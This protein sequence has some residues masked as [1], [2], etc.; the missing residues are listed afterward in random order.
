MDAMSIPDG[1]TLDI[2]WQAPLQAD[3]RDQLVSALQAY[4][5]RLIA[6]ETNP[7]VPILLALG[8]LSNDDLATITR[9]SR[10]GQRRVIAALTTPAIGEPQLAWQLL[11]RGASEVLSWSDLLDDPSSLCARLGRWH[12]IDRMASSSMVRDNLIGSSPAWTTL[13]RRVVEVAY[14]TSSTILLIGQS[15]TGKEMLARLIHTLDGRTAKRELVVLDCSTVLPEFAESEFFGHERGVLT[16]AQDARDGA[17]AFA[18]QGTLFLDNVDKLSGVMQAQ[19]L[20]VLNEQTFKRVGSNL[21][22]R[23]E[24]RLICAS[25]RDLWSEVN[26]GSFHRDL[27]HQLAGWVFRVPSLA[28]RREDIVPLARHLLAHFRPDLPEVEFVPNVA[29]WLQARDYPDNIVDLRQLLLRMNARHV[30]KGPI[31]LA[32]IPE[33]ERPT[34]DLQGPS[35]PDLQ[36]ERSI[37]RAIILGFGPNEISRAASGLALKM[38]SCPHRSWR[39]VASNLEAVEGAQESLERGADAADIISASRI[40]PVPRAARKLVLRPAETASHAEPMPADAS[41]LPRPIPRNSDLE[42]P[43]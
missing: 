10:S 22:Q 7:H 43:K 29:A 39:N 20:R 32:D 17:F 9:L 26:N 11:A 28:E 40:E 38:A 2:S 13:L 34:C 4:G 16:R 1:I 24:F 15:G 3:C 37:K 33:D 23:S 31:G 21:S 27:Y 6:E 18:N 35:W 25:H 8:D 41:G 42:K 12:T 14:F 30:G 19:L 5:V 36:F